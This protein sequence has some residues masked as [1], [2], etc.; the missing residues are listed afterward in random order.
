MLKIRL[1]GK[2]LTTFLEAVLPGALP[3]RPL[4]GGPPKKLFF[5]NKLG[6]NKNTNKIKK[7]Q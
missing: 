1:D 6:Y 5:K 4:G 3:G 2:F 7:T